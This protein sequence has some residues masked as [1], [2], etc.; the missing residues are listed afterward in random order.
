MPVS[1][2]HLDVYKRQPLHPVSTFILPRLSERVAQ[3][4]R[5]LFTFLSAEGTATLSAFL[6]QYDDS[7]KLVTPDLIFD[8]FEQLFKKEVYAGAIHDTYVLTSSI[9]HQL[10]AGSLESKIVKTISLIYILEQFERLSPTKEQIVGIYS[11]T[12]DV[13]DIENAIRKLIEQELSLIHI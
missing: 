8:Y 6:A 5:T 1:Y 7:F 3:N 9:L 2:T 4:E 12:Y 10:I 13:D 11:S